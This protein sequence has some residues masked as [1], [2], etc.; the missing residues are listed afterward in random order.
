MADEL[1]DALTY[2][3]LTEEVRL[4]ATSSRGTRA[5]PGSSQYGQIVESALRDIL[6]WRIRD[7]DPKGFL[8]A[9][10]QS[11][12]L[13]TVEGH[14]EWKWTPHTYAIEAD[15]GAVTGAQAAIYSR[16]RVAL[17]QSLPLLE[18]LQSLLAA[19]DEQEVEAMTAIIRSSMT[20][21]V[22]ELGV[23]G[24][25]RLT[26]V[27]EYFRLLLGDGPALRD[28]E[29]VGG[30]L[31]LLR[32]ALGLVRR[33]V[34][35]IAEEQNLT[36]FLI[37]V[38]YVTSLRLTW[39]AQRHFFDRKGTDVFLGTQ[40]VLLSRTLAVVAESVQEAYFIM[41][42]V[43]LGP[44]ERQVTELNLGTGSPVFLGELLDWIETF[45]L[46]E[47]PRLITQGGKDGVIS[48][49][50]P[51]AKRLSELTTAAAQLAVPDPLHPTRGFRTSRVAR[52]LGELA[53]DLNE[54]FALA[55]KVRRL[56]RPSVTA[57]DPE[58][59]ALGQP[60]RLTINGGHFVNG[61]EA[62]LNKSG[63]S[64]KE[65][66]P[67]KVVFVDEAELKATFDLTTGILA[68]T[69]TVVVVNPDGQHG[70]LKNAFSVVD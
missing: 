52:A 67:T 31:G 26:R 45:A 34:N 32:D 69:W 58:E 41:D 49:F 23:E 24:G 28:S 3:I 57:V 1:I 4:P 17:D 8:A 46:D 37:L 5:T 20:G 50:A 42:S 59:A 53:T 14:T 35:T 55:S 48:A 33:N 60:V 6:G 19:F 16:A 9:L 51:T 27:D 10:N 25:P 43:F 29:E 7:N 68:S 63:R 70:S 22:G 36:N 44:A 2:P 12:D 66:L 38:D 56:P 47:G 15:M 40:L 64:E 62:R 11:F 39:N 18:G 65:I 54:T 21:L 30:Q 61:A 13:T